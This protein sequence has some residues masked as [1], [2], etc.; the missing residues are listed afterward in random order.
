MCWS[1]VISTLC[2]SWLRCVKSA[3]IAMSALHSY[4]ARF[5]KVLRRSVSSAME[6]AS[7][8]T[9][10]AVRVERGRGRPLASSRGAKAAESEAA[11]ASAAVKSANRSGPKCFAA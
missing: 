1:P 11:G 4:A 2:S 3:P 10:K 9:S 7:A 8:G 5:A 6:V